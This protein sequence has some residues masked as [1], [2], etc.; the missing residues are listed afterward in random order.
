MKKDT[1][2]RL[3]EMMAVLNKDFSS[4]QKLNENIDGELPPV[5]EKCD[6]TNDLSVNEERT[7]L[8]EASSSQHV[9]IH[10]FNM[11]SLNYPND[12]IEKIWGGGNVIS[13]HLK[14]KFDHSYDQYGSK[15]AMLMFWTEL[16]S[17]NRRML[18]EYVID[19]YA[20]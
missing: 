7:E 1:E 10:K 17:E 15:A 19:N 14:M 20:G 18:Q 6:E 4:K 8:N 3:F 13:D 2:E 12:F 16:D 9:A 11:F 5:A